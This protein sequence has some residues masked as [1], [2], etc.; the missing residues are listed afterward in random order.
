[1]TSD[2]LPLSIVRLSVIGCLLAAFLACGGCGQRGPLTL[3]GS[4]QPP[5][6]PAAVPPIDGNDTDSQEQE[7]E[8]EPEN[9]P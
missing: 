9:E 8:Q 1:M 2:R 6:A 7:Q 4:A 3:P 5:A